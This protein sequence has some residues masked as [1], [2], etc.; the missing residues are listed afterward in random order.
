MAGQKSNPFAG[1]GSL[2]V[3]ILFCS[4]VTPGFPDSTA[5]E[6]QSELERIRVRAE[7]GEAAAQYKLAGHL[8]VQADHTNAVSWYR[9]AAEQG[10][11]E[12]QLALAAC[13][14][15]GRGV[16]KNL[17]EAARWH[18]FGALRLAQERR[19][20]PLPGPAGSTPPL[21]KRLVMGTNIAPSAA[22]ATNAAASVTPEIPPRSSRVHRK[23]TLPAPKSELENITRASQ[24]ETPQP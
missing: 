5:P 8:A 13:Y 23:D 15:H 16:E 14:A 12:A 11:A 9:K 3:I 21:P 18:R 17:D 4:L 6:A 19:P 22:S 24:S 7:A 20:P 10:L 1:L 2:G